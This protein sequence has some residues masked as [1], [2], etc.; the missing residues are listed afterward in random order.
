LE[1][2][3]KKY[4]MFVSIFS[5]CQFCYPIKTTKIFWAFSPTGVKKVRDPIPRM[6][7]WKEK[8]KGGR[9]MWQFFSMPSAPFQQTGLGE[10]GGL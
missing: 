4:K 7:N 2:W 3:N 6:G 5:F 8:K 10:G 9:E 1:F